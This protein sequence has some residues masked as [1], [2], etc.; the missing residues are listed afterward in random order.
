MTRRAKASGP[1]VGLFGLLGSGNLGND[2]ST[3]VIVRYLRAEHPDAVLDAMCAGWE[4]MR[5]RYGIHAVPYQWQ[6]AHRLPGGPLGAGLKVLGKALDV[7]H[8]AAW[9]RRHDVVIVPGMGIMEAALPINPWGVPWSLF[10][11]TAAGRLLRTKVALVSAGATPARNPMT[12]R[13]FT[14]AARLAYYRSF[15]DPLSREVLRRQGLDTSGDP[16][17]TDLV[18][19]LQVEPDAPVDPLAVGVGVMAYYGGNEDRDQADEIY[20]SYVSKLKCFVR[21]LIDSGRSVRLFVGDVVDQPV[22][23]EIM[24]DIRAYRPDL[25]PSRIN[26]TPVTTFAELTSML[27][28]VATVLATRFHNVVFALKLGKPTISVGY[29]PKND[30]LMTDLG[31]G[32]YLQDVKSLDIEKLKVQFADIEKRSAQV[33]EQLTQLLPERTA[34]ARAQLDDLNGVLFG[35]LG[36]VAGKPAEQA[37]NRS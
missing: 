18:Y 27:S 10:L 24:S 9:V 13:L 20:A 21:W 34:R 4:R 36:T 15:R 25:D 30:S 7:F 8:T 14:S 37:A 17:Y 1:R 19:G 23:D 26:G 11:L 22:A 31:L 3:E 2:A 16:V 33:R 28:P 35:A 5:D 29:S 32:Q 12:A 6:A